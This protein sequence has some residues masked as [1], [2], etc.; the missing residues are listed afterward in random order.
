MSEKQKEKL[1]K[2]APGGGDP[3]FDAEPAENK[4]V[5]VSSGPYLEELPVAGKTVGEIRRKF[6]DRFDIDDKAQAIINGDIADESAVL[7]AGEALMFVRHAGEK[8]TQVLVEEATATATTPEGGTRK[9]RLETLINR[10]TP[11]MDTGPCILP[12]GVKA[13]FSRGQTT[14]WVWERPPG[15]QKL[16]WIKPESPVPYG[17]GTLYRSVRI[18][19]PYLIIFAVFGRDEEG[20]PYVVKTDE[21]FFRTEPLG[22]LSDKLMF[23]GLLNCSK[24]NNVGKE[25]PMQPL[26]WICTQYLKATKGMKSKDPAERFTA[27]FEAV[28][29]CLLETAFNL[30]SEYHEGNS[31]FGA[32]KKVD[33]RIET[34]EAWEKATAEDPLFVLDVPW[35]NTNR[36]VKEIAE[37]IFDRT[38]ATDT[39]VK[40]AADLAR[41]I[42]NG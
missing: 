16:S 17:P 34:V 13:V 14:V 21:C 28:R 4:N 37:R 12:T 11:T 23:P 15:I 20:M 1:G 35:I 7:K 30:S 41:V 2:P 42:N 29:Y 24:F 40:S 27:S 10:I 22:S 6:K 5:S 25:H 19:L 18:G 33:K 31:W 32:S 26:S 3:I 9:M 36:T 39:S 38:G 8:G